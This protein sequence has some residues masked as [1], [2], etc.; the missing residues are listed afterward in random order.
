MSK[1]AIVIA[2]RLINYFAHQQSGPAVNN[3]SS[4]SKSKIASLAQLINP[5]YAHSQQKGLATLV[6]AAVRRRNHLP[7]ENLR[8]NV[9]WS[10]RGYRENTI[11]LMVI[12]DTE[13]RKSP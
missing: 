3:I 11:Y 6:I 9:G 2:G 8:S 12:F 4:R 10:F 7:S 5:N 13:H 1:I